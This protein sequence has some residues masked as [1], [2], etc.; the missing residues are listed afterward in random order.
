MATVIT[1]PVRA[2][3]LDWKS[4]IAGAVAAAAISGLLTA[5]GAT[6]G[7]S[8]TSAHRTSG[9][10]ISAL[11]IAGALWMVMVHIWSFT[12]GGYLAGR[13]SEVPDLEPDEAQFRAGANGFMVWAV[14]TAI[15][16]VFLALAAGTEVRT[17]AQVAGQAASGVA[18]A[19]S[20]ISS[21]NVS[22][23]SDALFRAQASPAGTNTPASTQN[24]PDPVTVAEAGRI[25]TVSLV[26]GSLSAADRAYLA[27]IVS[28]QTGLAEAEAQRR[29]D[30][31]YARAQSMK[32]TA[33]RRVREVADKAR[34]QAVVA[35]FL[36]AAASLTGLVAAVWAAGAGRE[37]QTSR[38]YP[39][40]F[41]SRRFW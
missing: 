32:E 17:T 3:G 16:L 33:E 1:T 41:G 39:S 25:I 11:A 7:L 38:Q 37:H 5:F 34:K 15:G 8:L 4:I 30:E 29:V 27:Q 18:Q 26:E 2:G 21:E 28:R 9:L 35:G 31:T 23:V 40:A 22:Y 19:A 20:N 10:S 13:I 24:R 36:A 12:A 14:G 6:I